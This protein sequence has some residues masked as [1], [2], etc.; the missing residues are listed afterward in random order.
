MSEMMATR[1]AVEIFP[2]LIKVKMTTD[3]IHV[4]LDIHRVLAP[5]VPPIFLRTIVGRLCCQI[6]CESWERMERRL[7]VSEGLLWVR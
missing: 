6:S 4:S 2:R 5:V 7:G 1:N 3:S